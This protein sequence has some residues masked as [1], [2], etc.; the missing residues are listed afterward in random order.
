MHQSS[1]KGSPVHIAA[2]PPLRLTH[3]L[4]E[5]RRRFLRLYRDSLVQQIRDIDATLSELAA[6]PGTP[7]RSDG[8][9]KRAPVMTSVDSMLVP[10][11]R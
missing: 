7:A 5:G 11:L 8:S 1:T 3:S 9:R 10:V 4:A 2:S 6:V